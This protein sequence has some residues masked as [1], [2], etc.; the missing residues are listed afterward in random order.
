MNRRTQA[1]FTLVVALIM[2][3][4]LLPSCTTQPAG[5][6]QWEYYKPEHVKCYRKEIKVCRQYGPHLLCAC[7][8]R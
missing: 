6:S 2:L 1:I 5:V 4:L 7:H 3:V 8:S